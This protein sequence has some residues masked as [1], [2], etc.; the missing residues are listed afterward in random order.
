MATRS[1]FSTWKVVSA[2]V[3]SRRSRSSSPES[4]LESE[5]RRRELFR[6]AL[7][8]ARARTRSCPSAATASSPRRCIRL[9]RELADD[10]AALRAR[11][12]AAARDAVLGGD[13]QHPEVVGHLAERDR[14]VGGQE[15]LGDADPVDGGAVRAAEVAHPDAVAIVLGGEFGVVAGHGRIEDRHV[16]VHGAADEQGAADRKLEAL[17]AA[18]AD[19]GIEWHGGPE[20]TLNAAPPSGSAERRRRP[21]GGCRWRDGWSGAS[22]TGCRRPPRAPRPAPARRGRR[23]A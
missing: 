15:A 21:P 14:V 16:A 19:E 13:L 8:A 6:L 5:S 20:S 10:R 17:V 4:R 1:T 23:S 22:G 12:P 11:P 2:T 3:V 7:R 18:E 9:H